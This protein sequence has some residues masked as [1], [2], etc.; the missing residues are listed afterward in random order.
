MPRGLTLSCLSVAS[1]GVVALS[2]NYNRAAFWAA[3]ARRE[4]AREA[5]DVTADLVA[6]VTDAET[7]QRGF[8]LTGRPVY[9]DPYHVGMAA[10][11]QKAQRLRELAADRPDLLALVKE[12]DRELDAKLTELAE[13]VDRTATG[14]KG[15]AYTVVLSDR[16]KRSMERIRRG[17]RELVGGFD[18]DAAAARRHQ[19]AAAEVTRLH[20]LIGGTLAV[21]LAIAAAVANAREAR[22]LREQIRRLVGGRSD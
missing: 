20:L 8:L 18:L 15:G 13:T 6:A 12:L 22:R 16:G 17:C 10:A 1:A 5:R 14:D 7:G 9:L 11:P 19:I 4:T 2:W 3:D 21:G